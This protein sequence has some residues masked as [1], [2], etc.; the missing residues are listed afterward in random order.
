MKH[1][2]GQVKVVTIS[3]ECSNAIEA[4]NMLQENT[5]DLL[6]LDIEMPGMSGRELA[7]A[8]GAIRPLIIFTTSKKEYASEAYELNVIHMHESALTDAYRRYLP[9]LYS[10]TLKLLYTILFFSGLAA[11]IALSYYLLMMIDS[12]KN[13]LTLAGMSGMMRIE[14]AP[15]NTRELANYIEALFN[16]KATEK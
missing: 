10:C 3:G 2:A 15:F 1:I 13:A 11:F 7:K 9:D 8:L 5:A 14:S 6:L 4:Y 12:G 16:E